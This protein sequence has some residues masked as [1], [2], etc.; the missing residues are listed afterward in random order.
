MDNR[1]Y[2]IYF[3]T[4]TVSGI[5]ICAILF[6]MFFA[7]S[8]A[9]FKDELATWQHNSVVATAPV[10]KNF[11]KVIDSLAG[12]HNLLGRDFDF[13]L[14]EGH[15]SAYVNMT[16]SN[17]TILKKK[18]APAQQQKKRGR[19]RRGDDDSANFSY[20]FATQ[21]AGSYEENYDIG[22]FLYRLHFLAPLNAIPINIGT[23]FGYFLAGIVS[24]IF[25]FALVTGLM[26]HWDKMVS[27]FFVF[28]PWSKWKTMWTDMHTALGVIGFLFQL[29]FAITG[30]VLIANVF[31]LAPYSQILYKGNTKAI[32]K[33]LGYSDTTTYAYSYKPL[34]QKI[35]ITALVGKVEQQWPGAYVGAVHIKNYGDENMHVLVDTKPHAKAAFAGAGFFVYRVTDSKTLKN[36]SPVNSASY[37]EN[38]KSL[39][40]HLHFGDYGGRPLRIIYFTL[41][42]LGCVVII[43]GILIWLVARDKS[44][45]P[46]H[47]R[48]FNFWAANVFVASCLSLL[49]V[50]AFTMLALLFVKQVNQSVVYHYFFYA[51][52]VLSIYFIALRSLRKTNLHSL[53]L[54]IILCFLVP[55]LD[56]AIRGNWLWTTYSK[57][58]LDVLFVDLLFLGLALVSAIALLK[59]R[60]HN[61]EKLQEA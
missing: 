59:M 5:I 28:R 43:S 35:N 15:T 8:F 24:F 18:V 61:G 47:K 44:K 55:I 23:P 37:V 11:D 27:N 19:K 45:T 52:L 39:L 25:L 30:I 60:K 34:K 33:D 48:I 21:K 1:K 12:K 6:V 29:I 42:L 2:N 50:T 51:W 57:G 56:G 54:S 53:A 40:Y 10:H 46:K 17:D 4:H 22:E 3:N 9:F 7:G 32:Y 13:Y 36:I 26:L 14:A 16:A 20:D 58:A 38:G 49:P 41:G 31:F